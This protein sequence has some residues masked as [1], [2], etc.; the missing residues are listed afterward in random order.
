MIFSELPSE[1]TVRDVVKI[2][3]P[4][5]V[6]NGDTTSVEVQVGNNKD[7]VLD[8]QF[9]SLGSDGTVGTFGDDLGLDVTSVVGSDYL[10]LKRSKGLFT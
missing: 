1:T 3:Q 4:F 7:L 9:V 10:E 8:E 2:L 6:R 5:E